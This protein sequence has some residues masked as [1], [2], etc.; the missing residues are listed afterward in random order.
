MPCTLGRSFVW[1]TGMT[2]ALVAAAP[3]SAQD[4]WPAEPL[5]SATDLTDIEGPG[6]NDF[7][8]DLSGAV[9]NPVTRTLWVCRNGPGGSNSKLW[10]VVEDGGGG[11]EIDYRGGDRGE[12]LL[13]SGVQDMGFLRPE[14]PSIGPLAQGDPIAGPRLPPRVS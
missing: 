9:W 11:F 14:V 12:E 2:V 7:H 4:S 10:A 5:G 13:G 1:L 8:Y 6:V 3:V